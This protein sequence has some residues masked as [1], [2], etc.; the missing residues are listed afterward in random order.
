MNVDNFGWESSLSVVANEQ[1]RTARPRHHHGNSVPTLLRPVFMNAVEVG[2][3]YAHCDRDKKLNV[4]GVTIALWHFICRGHQ[5]IALL[6]YCFKNYAEKSS[7]YSELMMLY[8]LNLIEFTPGYGSEKYTEVNRIMVNRAYETGGCLV[9]RS[10]MQGITDNKSHLIDV[11]EQRLLMPTFNGDDIMFPIDGPLGR[12]GPS[13]EQTLQCDQG[14]SDWR[15][16]SEHQLLLSDQRHWLEK[17]AL[18]VPEKVVWTRMVQMIQGGGI[19]E[20]IEG[21]GG[22]DGFFDEPPSPPLEN[23]FHR[24]TCTVPSNTNIHNDHGPGQAPPDPYQPHGHPA[25]HIPNPHQLHHQHRRRYS[26]PRRFHGNHQPRRNPSSTRLVIRYGSSPPEVVGRGGVD[27]GGHQQQHQHQRRTSK[28]SATTDSVESTA[29]TQSGERTES[30]TQSIEADEDIAR[31]LDAQL[32]EEARRETEKRVKEE[33]DQRKK[34]ELL[35]KLSQI[36]GYAK[37]IRV[38]KKYP[39]MLTLSLLVEKC[40]QESDEAGDGGEFSDVW[41]CVAEEIRALPTPTPTLTPTPELVEDL[42]DFSDEPL[43][44]S[45][46][47]SG[48]REQETRNKESILVDLMF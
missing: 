29:S 24:Q 47:M 21:A 41:A 10:Q 32:I 46:E 18:L 22:N 3:S 40:M 6:P 31:E 17:L 2:Y 16:C 20:Q 13:L 1:T 33:A 45:V 5:A 48:R 23:P 42:I 15:S 27:G 8:R 38:M 37:S 19:D 36:F 43:I 28:H 44:P 9:A 35:A 39:K 25:H 12:N 7:R 4:R 34:D 11:V 14:L 26:S 30:S